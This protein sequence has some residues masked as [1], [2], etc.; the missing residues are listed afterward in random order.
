MCGV[1]S[2]LCVHSLCACMGIGEA[3]AQQWGVHRSTVV[4]LFITV[5]HYFIKK[6]LISV[7]AA[8]YLAS[9]VCMGDCFI[10]YV[11]AWVC[12]LRGKILCA[13]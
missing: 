3:R 10:L 13:P 9:A 12:A 4:T 7:G 5:S 8:A 11:H 1:S 6:I 2:Q